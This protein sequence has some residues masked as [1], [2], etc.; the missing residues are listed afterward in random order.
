MLIYVSKIATN[1]E[2]ISTKIYSHFFFAAVACIA[3]LQERVRCAAYNG[4]LLFTSDHKGVLHLWNTG[5]CD[6]QHC[7]SYK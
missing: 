5:V 4:K 1:F 2:E 6:L 3:T 7:Q